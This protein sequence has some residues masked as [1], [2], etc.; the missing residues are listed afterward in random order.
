MRFRLLYW[1]S[2]N[3]VTLK[4][5]AGVCYRLYTETDFIALPRTTKPEIQRVSLTFAILHLFASGQEDV[6]SF[7]FMDRPAKESSPSF[8][9][10]RSFPS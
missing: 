5:S 6:W 8:F 2:P 3:L 1:N 4:Q 10:S 9:P 7:A